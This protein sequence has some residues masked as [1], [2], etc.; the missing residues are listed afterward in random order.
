MNIEIGANIK[1]L[2]KARGVTQEALADW[3]G[4]SFQ[5]VSKWERGDGYPDITMLLPL[6]RFF[7]VTLDELMGTN[8]LRDAEEAQKLLDET[9]AN[10][11]DG[12]IEESIAL[13][14]DGVKRY[15]DNDEMWTELARNLR[16]LHTNEANEEAI[17]IL[18]RVLARCADSCIRNRA[19]TFLCYAYSDAGRREKAAQIAH[20]LPDVLSSRLI[21]VDFLDGDAKKSALQNAFISTVEA[22]DWQF[23]RLHQIGEL[24]DRDTIVMLQKSLAVLDIVLNGEYL[25]LAVNVAERYLWLAKAHARLGEFGNARDALENA[26][27]YAKEY[28]HQPDVYEYQSLLLR[29]L[30]F[31]KNDY[32]KE[33][34]EPY[35]DWLKA[36]MQSPEFAP[37]FD[38]NQ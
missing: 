36:Q 11:T 8:A 10:G 12:K 6:A 25:H 20:T 27:K 28:D 22:L 33:F 17:D 19:Q 4:V 15:H 13:L 29:G 2:R 26:V 38:I 14:R 21:E 1:R 35:A 37:L 34:A 24:D 9:Y 3:I 16:M 30:I 7:G 18:E 31:H 23:Y 5:A 32:S